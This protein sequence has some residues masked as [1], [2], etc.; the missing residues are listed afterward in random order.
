[1]EGFFEINCV[2]TRKNPLL[3]KEMVCTPG[4][5]GSLGCA[6]LEIPKMTQH[7]LN[8]YP[9]RMRPERT[10]T[11]KNKNKNKNARQNSGPCSPKK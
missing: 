10:A 2:L 6:H 9:A 11:K 1:M 7:N 8:P 5:V 3:L 4:K